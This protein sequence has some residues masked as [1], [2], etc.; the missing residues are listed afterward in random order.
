M[1]HLPLDMTVALYCAKEIREPCMDSESGVNNRDLH[2]YVAK[3]AVNKLE[4]P[5]AIDFLEDV[6]R[7]YDP[8]Y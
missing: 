5:L 2:L 4:N 7:E 6:I 1:K 3:M 8:T